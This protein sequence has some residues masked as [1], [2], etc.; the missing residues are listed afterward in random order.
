MDA[1]PTHRG[2]QTLKEAVGQNLNLYTVTPFLKSLR[3]WIKN[4]QAET[5]SSKRK[6]RQKQQAQFAQQ[7]QNQ[8]QEF[9]QLKK[10]KSVTKTLISQR[11][12]SVRYSREL[13]EKNTKQGRRGMTVVQSLFGNKDSQTVAEF[14][15][16]LVDTNSFYSQVWN[17]FTIDAQ[18]LADMLP[19]EGCYYLP[20]HFDIGAV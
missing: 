14:K 16:P 5:P 2:D 18:S 17:D 10:G 20:K 9:M 15:A 8:Y 1:L 6:N 7:A 19:R 12:T 4:H 13:Q 11:S 3:M